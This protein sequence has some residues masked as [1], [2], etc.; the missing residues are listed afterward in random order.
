MPTELYF[1]GGIPLLLHFVRPLVLLSTDNIR[2]CLQAY[3]SQSHRTP[4]TKRPNGVHIV[5]LVDTVMELTIRH[6]NLCSGF[7]VRC[8]GAVLSCDL[9]VLLVDGQ[10]DSDAIICVRCAYMQCALALC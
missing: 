8:T 5:L 2:Y 7:S 1:G 6:L 4:S 9:S 3:G 10:L